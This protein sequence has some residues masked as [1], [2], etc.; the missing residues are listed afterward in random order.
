MRKII[1]FLCIIF[2]YTT[3]IAQQIGNGWTYPISDF[4]SLLN[5]GAYEAYN[6]SNG[7]PDTAHPWQ[8]LF[9]MRHSQT[10]N[11][12]QFQLGASYA[13]ND[14]LFFR[15][16]QSG[17]LEPKNSTWNE[18]ATRGS[19]TF[20]GNQNIVGNLTI[21]N[22]LTFNHQRIDFS[23]APRTTLNP[24]SLKL[25]DNYNNGG[26]TTYGT[27]MEIYGYGGHQTSQLHF[28]GWDNSRIRYRE[29]FYNQNTWSDWVTLLDSK[30]DVESQGNLKLSGNGIHYFLNGNV[31]VG[32]N[33]PKA[34]LEVAGGE[35]MCSGLNAGF[36]VY[37]SNGDNVNGAPWYG[38]GV[39]NT[40]LGFGVSNSTVQLAGYYGLNFQT[41]QGRMVMLNNGNVGIGVT[42]P[43]NIL[44]I[45]QSLQLGQN[46][47]DFIELTKIQ[48]NGF[49]NNIYINDFINRETAGG[50]WISTSYIKGVSIDGSY[51]NPTTL[52]S[53]IKQVPYEDKIDFGSNGKTY[54]SIHRDLNTTNNA[55]LVVDGVIHAKEVKVDLTA[56]LADYVF[57]SDYSLMPLHKVEAFVKENK[58]LP[59][60][61]SAAEVKEK[62]LSMGEMQNKLLQKIEE[63]T[64]YVIE[65]E[66]RVNDLTDKQKI[67]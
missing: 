12:H 8:H 6:P 23:A 29:A 42:Q 33:D 55:V 47:G 54:M 60:I 17:I 66:K 31:G 43:S 26:P 16:I 20:N 34:K 1:V 49:G 58:H 64:L 38:L 32:T 37:S 67:N 15:K 21:N 7:V 13:E 39:S 40:D 62:G 9:V 63:L 4:S 19:N 35:I 53:W 52:K 10:T 24:M 3:V 36:R 50:D 2:T 11:N 25:W 30:N 61:P 48:G 57:N 22:A 46:K 45:K 51:V 44:H 27:V 41:A 18:L 5:T 28:G 65:L 14:R 59:A 56:D